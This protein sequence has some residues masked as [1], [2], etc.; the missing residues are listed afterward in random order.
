MIFNLFKLAGSLMLLV[1]GFSLVF[2]QEDS[3]MTH[4]YPQPTG[5]YPIGVHDFEF[6]DTTYPVLRPEDSNG[7]KLFVRVWYPAADTSGE[8]R[9]YFEG[10]ELVMV[11]RPMLEAISMFVPDTTLLDPLAD[12]LTYSYKDAAIAK[13]VSDA[14]GFPTLVFSHGGLGNLGQNTAIMEE[15]ASRGYVV[16]SLSHPGQSGGVLYLNGDVDAYDADFHQAVITAST[17]YEPDGIFSED[18]SKRYESRTSRWLDDN[19]LGPWLPRWR[20]DKIAMVDYIEAAQGA[21]Q[22]EGLLADILAQSDLSRLAYFGMSYGASAAASAAHADE[23]AKAA[24][25]FDGTHHLSDLLDTNIRVPLLVLT[26]EPIDHSFS[27]EFFFEPLVSMGER[28]DITRIWI[29]EVTHLELFDVMFLPASHREGFPGGG[30]A[31]GDEVHAI[32]IGFMGGFF[33]HYLK[34]Q[35]NGY[36]QVFFEQFPDVRDVDLSRIREWA[37]MR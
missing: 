37:K 29:P 21:G 11:G 18:I 7:R 28:E 30:V 20:D 6:V 12:V 13:D 8:R 31:D 3:P 19:A 34:G 32:L 24:I 27:N 26:T 15:L 36:P 10:K 2:A 4:T 25:V 35:D 22:T 23:R 1:T 16:F 14:G 9:K 5:T 17:T 33:D